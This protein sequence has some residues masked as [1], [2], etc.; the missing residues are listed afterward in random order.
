MQTQYGVSKWPSL[1]GMF[2]LGASKFEDGKPA[3]GADINSKFK[4]EGSVVRRE[5]LEFRITCQVE[6]IL[7]NG[8][9]YIE[10][11]DKDTLAE[12]GKILELTGYVR[13][14]DIQP[15][16]TIKGELIYQREIRE[17]PSGSAYD[18]SRRNWA[19]KL[20]DQYA[21]F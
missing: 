21:P 18:S 3:I 8:V 12:E 17:I 5:Q 16:N 1:S 19:Q 20:V 9:L 15:D 6:S 4:N 2:G 7:E 13:P 11:T 14:Q 10:G